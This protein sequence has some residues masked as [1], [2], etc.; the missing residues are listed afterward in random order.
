MSLLWRT[1]AWGDESYDGDEDHP[2]HELYPA[3]EAAGI[4]HAPCMMSR[5]PDQ[6]F[7]H[8]DVFDRAEMIHFDHRERGEELPVRHIDLT[9]PVYGFEPTADMH[10][11]RHYQRRGSAKLPVVFQHQ[12]Q[13]Y[14]MDGH[15][16]VAAAMR[17]GDASM[18]VRHI[19]LDNEH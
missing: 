11:M 6:D 2:Q 4:R 15:H 14:I 13:Q 5:C 3:F 12:G 1:A 17:R 16:R 18:P 19:D 7:D 8:T 10:Q 9:K